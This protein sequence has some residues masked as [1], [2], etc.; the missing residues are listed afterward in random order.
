MPDT[1]IEISREQ[2]QPLHRL[3]T[4]HASGIGDVYLM[5]EAGDFATAGWSKKLRRNS[6]CLSRP[7]TGSRSAAPRSTGARFGLRWSIIRCDGSI[8]VTV[9]S[10][11]S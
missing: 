3:A 2:R 5:I 11:G 8:A 7:S 9:M 1:T 6:A 10:T 4:Q